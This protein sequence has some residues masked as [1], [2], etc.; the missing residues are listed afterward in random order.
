MYAHTEAL[1]LVSPR[2][3]ETTAREGEKQGSLMVNP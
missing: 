1:I 2:H 3:F